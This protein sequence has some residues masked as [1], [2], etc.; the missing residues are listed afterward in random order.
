[1]IEP[2]LI[3]IGAGGHARACIDVIEALDTFRIAGLIGTEDE[4]QHEC[5]GYDILGVDDDLANLVNKYRHA[6]ITVGQIESSLVRQSLYVQALEFGF[7]FPAIISPTAHVSRRSSVGDG[8]IVMHGAIVNAGARVGENCIV[9][10]NA[11]IEHDATVGDHC[12]ISTGAIVNGEVSIGFGSFVGSGSIIK[13][14]ITIGSRC[15][16]GMGVSVRHNYIES[17]KIVSGRK[18]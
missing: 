13:Q 15:V 10:S 9:N 2:N 7:E 4:L 3:L 1:M 8:S 5:M 18:S 11:L 6:L 12:H 17:S 16:I 14:G